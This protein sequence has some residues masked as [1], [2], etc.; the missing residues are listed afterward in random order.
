MYIMN[1][2]NVTPIFG[3]LQIFLIWE[4]KL[5]IVISL[6][7]SCLFTQTIHNVLF[8]QIKKQAK[9]ST[10]F[11]HSSRP[12]ASTLPKNLSQLFLRAV[13]PVLFCLSLGVFWSCL[14]VFWLLLTVTNTHP[15][16]A[17]VCNLSLA[18]PLHAHSSASDWPCT[19]PLFRVV[20][21]IVSYSYALLY[22]RSVVAL[23]FS[24]NKGR[25]AH[26]PTKL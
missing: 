5:M 19:C 9:G 23:T 25:L 2:H 11:A 12:L 3:V 26:P 16:P 21:H 7:Q 14:P 15:H 1:V 22:K 18:K 17:R 24:L 6:R 13:L 4:E 10:F 20:T 8:P